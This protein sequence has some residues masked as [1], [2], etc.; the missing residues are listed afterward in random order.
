ME[1]KLGVKKIQLLEDIL[2]RTHCRENNQVYQ[3]N[4]HKF[5]TKYHLSTFIVHCTILV[6]EAR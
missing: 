2:F 6:V 3:N 1:R 4:C 5:V